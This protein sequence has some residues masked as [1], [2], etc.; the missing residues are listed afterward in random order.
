M[1]IVKFSS[2][3]LFQIHSQNWIG[4]NCEGLWR[5]HGGATGWPIPPVPVADWQVITIFQLKPFVSFL[6]SKHSWHASTFNITPVWS[7]DRRMIQL[8]KA[9]KWH[10]INTFSET[11]LCFWLLPVKTLYEMDVCRVGIFTTFHCSLVLMA[12]ISTRTRPRVNPHVSTPVSTP[13]PPCQPR[14]RPVK[15][16]RCT[17]FLCLWNTNKFV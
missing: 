16:R 5:Y 8:E 6:G 12:T 7:S 1:W 11:P 13:W 2:C 3:F 4:K 17:V 14:T 9:I 10:G 15:C